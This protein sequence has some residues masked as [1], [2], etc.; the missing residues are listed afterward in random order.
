MTGRCASGQVQLSP[1]HKPI[2]AL[3]SAV[4][5]K[6]G[7]AIKTASGADII[8]RFDTIWHRCQKQNSYATYF[9]RAL[10]GLD[11]VVADRI[12]TSLPSSDQECYHCLH[13]KPRT[14]RHHPGA[15][16]QDRKCRYLCQAKP[17]SQRMKSS[18]QDS[19][20]A[21]PD[22]LMFPATNPYPTAR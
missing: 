15:R 21:C 2:Q 3:P 6:R 9:L 13:Q 5:G 17:R 16:C 22:D 14:R 20:Q 12:A 19:I 7:E 8:L 10:C 11:V 18:G 1:Y 4:D